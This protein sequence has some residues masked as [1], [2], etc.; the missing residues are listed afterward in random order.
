M[1]LKMAVFAPMPSASYSVTAAVNAGRF[2]STRMAYRRSWARLC[3]KGIRHL[4]VGRNGRSD[5]AAPGTSDVP[6]A[7]MG[8]T[9]ET[10]DWLA[11]ACDYFATVSFNASNRIWI[12]G[13]TASTGR[14][15]ASPCIDITPS[16]G[17]MTGVKP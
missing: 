7:V 16:A 8:S 6:G 2:R 3:R 12:A 17:T 1:R 14:N 10:A 11:R 4:D 13:P 15:S 9:F 5:H